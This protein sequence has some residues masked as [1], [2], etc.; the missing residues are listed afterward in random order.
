MAPRQ[1]RTC[2]KKTS[3]AR[4][5]LLAKPIWKDWLFWVWLLALPA[6]FQATYWWEENGGGGVDS[7]RSW[8]IQIVGVWVVVTALLAL[9]AVVRSL[10]RRRVA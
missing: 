6:S 8:T 4:P 5:Q 1:S 7:S 3:M 9:A 2:V 10:Y